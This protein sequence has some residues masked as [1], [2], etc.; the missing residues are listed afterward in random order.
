MC[1]FS[2][3]ILISLLLILASLPCLSQSI[4]SQ[5]QFEDALAKVKKGEPVSMKLLPGTYHLSEPITAKGALSII[6]LGATIEAYTD[7]YSPRNAVRETPSHYVCKLKHTL[8]EYSLMV[9]Q[10][11]CLVEVSESVNKETYVNTTAIIEGTYEK[12]VGVEVRIP[13]PDNLSHL[14][15]KSYQK[16]FGYFDCGWSRMCFKLKKTDNKYLY[17]ETLHATNVPRYDYEKSAYKKDIRYVM[18]NAEIKT[19]AVYYDNDYIYIPKS[20]KSLKVKNCDIFENATPDISINGDVVFT[21]IT[22]AGINGINVSSREKNRCLFTGCNFTHTIGN[23]LKITKKSEKDFLPVYL[24]RCTFN[25]CALL[26][27]VM[28]DM[29]STNVGNKSIYVSDCNFVRYPDAK[30][31]YKNTSAMVNVNADTRISDCTFWNTCRC[32]L[33]F[34]R[35]NSESVGNVIYNTPDFN[36]MKDRNLSNDWGLIYVNHVYTDNE[37]AKANKLHKVTIEKCFLYGAYANA[38]DARGVMID[39]GRGDIICKNNVV[40]DCQCYSLDAREAKSFVGTSSI[41]NVFV[42]NILGCRYRLAGG[43][44]VPLNE[45]PISR[46]NILLSDYNNVFN[47]RS[48]IQVSNKV[49]TVTMEC[50]E[51]KMYVSK[52]DYKH[53]RSIQFFKKVKKYIRK[54]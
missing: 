50:K 49:I 2:N 5:Q 48:Q 52:G 42:N 33:Y 41:R 53:M 29:S 8:S 25:E 46:G 34:T 21:G 36:A 44:E 3:R 17:C 54:K 27:D 10:N 14:K 12:R 1:H 16:A 32:H 47:D 7:I 31:R 4:Y 20:V 51:G 45:R 23:A 28:L 19:G 38:N 9:D 13:I 39:N 37:K 43:V 22:F 11:D 26:W 6:G 40:L 24:S 18:Y 35:G 15:N 30:V